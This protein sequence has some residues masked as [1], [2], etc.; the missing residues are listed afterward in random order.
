MIAEGFSSILLVLISSRVAE[1]NI[2]SFK[3]TASAVSCINITDQHWIR[4]VVDCGLI[5]VRSAVYD[6]GFI[7]DGGHC[8]ICRS[9]DTHHVSC[10]ISTDGVSVSSPHHIKG[11]IYV[12]NQHNSIIIYL[13]S[14]GY[15]HFRLW[16]TKSI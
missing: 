15:H 9:D 14:G 16:I 12:C 8:H 13:F 1:S 4:S 6:Q 7:Y 11:N 5:A 2:Y 3:S 10:G